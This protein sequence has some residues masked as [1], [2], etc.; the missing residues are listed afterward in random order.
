MQMAVDI[1]GTDRSGAEV[2]SLKRTLLA[3]PD[4]RS[5]RVDEL[6]GPEASGAMGVLSEGLLLAFGAGGV[7]VTVV[8]A[9]CGWLAGR[10]P[11]V[12][13]RITQGERTVEIDVTRARNAEEV[14]ALYRQLETP[15]ENVPDRGAGA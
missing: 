5:V 8:Q 3:D 13:L 12:R 15:P 7:G 10:R 14:L 9:L 1:A 4:L 2:A 11:G 6:A